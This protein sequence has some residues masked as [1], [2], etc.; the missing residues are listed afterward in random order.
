M[1]D[2]QYQDIQSRNT[3]CPRELFMIYWHIS[4]ILIY[5]HCALSVFIFL[6]FD[7]E[8]A[9]LNLCSRVF[10]PHQS[11]CVCF[12]EIREAFNGKNLPI[13]QR[14][15]FAVDS[16]TVWSGISKRLWSKKKLS[17]LLNY[18]LVWIKNRSFIRSTTKLKNMLK[19]SKCASGWIV[20]I[21]FLLHFQII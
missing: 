15:K 20:C 10:E 16:R 14:L 7:C 2:L 21:K 11:I 13:F 9:R 1:Q 5:V 4:F 12:K 18:R 3:L 17:P 19:L 8:R 6:T